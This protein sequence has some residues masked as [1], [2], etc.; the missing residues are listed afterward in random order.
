VLF[1]VIQSTLCGQQREN[2][3]ERTGWYRLASP[4][5]NRTD[6][7]K[8][9][10]YSESSEA[11]TDL[12][13]V[14]KTLSLSR[15]TISG[16]FSSASVRSFELDPEN[17]T[18]LTGSN[19]SGKSTIL[20]SI[21]AVEKLDFALLSRLPFEQVTLTFAE[22]PPLSLVRTETGLDIGH[23]SRLWQFHLPIFNELRRD[24]EREVE[25][26]P[27]Y[28]RHLMRQTLRK[29][30]ITQMINR[31][32]AGWVSAIAEEFPVLLIED[33]RLQVSR[34]TGRFGAAPA[35]AE[36]L[37]VAAVNEFARELSAQID[38]TENQYA[39]VSQELDEAFYKK[40]IS[41][42]D[43]EV[44]MEALEALLT[45]VAEL[46]R[47]LRSV[48][49][50]GEEQEL[51][52]DSRRLQAEAVRPV[53]KTFAEDTLQKYAVLMSLQEQLSVF[54]EFLEKHY[55]EKHVAIS[56][57]HGFRIE[58]EDGRRLAPG[59]LSSGEQ[60]ILTLAYQLVFKSRPGTLVLIDEPELSL[61]V[62][63]QQSLIEDLRSLGE[64][65]DL[66]FLLATHSP[67]VIGDRPELVRSLG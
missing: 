19:G 15:Y 8:Q 53:I 36:G 29:K 66:S 37:Q 59:Q 34:R 62:N 18:I 61:H 21:N 50:L 5:K 63:W 31:D 17:P 30:V 67:T 10:F 11:P 41:A 43:H 40:V 13:A 56:H 25:G 42:L 35:R 60:Q 9:I 28:R 14:S 44:S 48:G 45:E 4:L 57:E 46:A 64:H 39:K 20:K 65:Q 54:V 7:K 27:N 26:A 3:H 6:L 47:R 22:A 49:L 38:R 12:T 1:V 24:A 55:R 58:L 51:G 2:S 16:L 32:E 33:Q 52:A 23:D